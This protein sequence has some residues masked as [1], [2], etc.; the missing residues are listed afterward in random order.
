MEKRE[1][2]R[3]IDKLWKM[4]KKELDKVL[5]DTTRLINKGES[6][7]KKMSKEAEK[8]MEVMVLSLQKK[9]L[10]YELGKSLASLPKNKWPVSKKIDAL[11]TEVNAISRKIKK[12]NK[13]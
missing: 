5:K 6:R 12:I 2:K 7:I 4:G 11:L 1:I 8:N 10:S 3:N 13:K 9:K